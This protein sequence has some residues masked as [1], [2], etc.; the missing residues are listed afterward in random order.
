MVLSTKFALAYL[1][2]LLPVMGIAQTA[3]KADTGVASYYS[4]KFHGRR[5]ASGHMFH[6]DSMTA[7]HK[8]LPFGTRVKV[9]NLRNQKTVVVTINDRGMKGKKRI[10]DLSPAAA[11]KL[12][13]LERGLEKVRVEVLTKNDDTP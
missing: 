4:H 7:A 8:H 3:T 6:T 12:G 11:K 2:M 5:T 1:F 13:M 10:I 9:T